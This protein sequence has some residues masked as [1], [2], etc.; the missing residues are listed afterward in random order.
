M[1]PGLSYVFIDPTG[2]GPFTT[3]TGQALF[4]NGAGV[5]TAPGALVAPVVLPVGA[6][7]R[8]VTLAY[9]SASGSATLSLFR[10]PLT[11][12][13]AQ[14][15]ADMVLPAGAGVQTATITVNEVVD[16]QSTFMAAFV[17]S[18]TAQRVSSLFAGFVPPPAKPAFVPVNPVNRVLDT[19]NGSGKLRP[20]EERVVPLA[21]PGTA[22]A[23]VINLTITETEGAGGFVSVFAANQPWPGNS[24]INWFVADE[25]V[26]NNVVTAIDPSGAIKIRGAVANTHVVIDVQGYLQ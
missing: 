21:V 3:A 1:T 26:A 17:A 18:T 5:V 4:S 25:N 6:T 2:F 12:S 24:S 22:S 10:K 15:G 8:E 19:R 13:Y 7:L 9:V 11:G 23:A 14:V 16:G 20:G